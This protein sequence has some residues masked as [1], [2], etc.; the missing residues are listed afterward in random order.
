MAEGR[1][2]R[3][4]DL[5]LGVPLALGAFALAV[6]AT[7]SNRDLF[8]AA[9]AWSRTTG[10]ALW[11]NVT[12]LGDARLVVVLALPWAVRRPRVLW[13]LLVAAVA[14]ALAV[15][16]IKQVVDAQRPAHVVRD[17]NLIGPLRGKRS[18]PSGHA[19]S[20][21]LLAGLACTLGRNGV[22]RTA[23]LLLAGA[24]AA[25]RVVIGVHWPLD[26]LCGGI[27]GWAAALAGAHVASRA[28]WASWDLERLGTRLLAGLIAVLGMWMLVDPAG[29]PRVQ[30]LQRLAAA[31]SLVAGAAA[32]VRYEARTD[33]GGSGAPGV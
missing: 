5:R 22:A 26:V 28:P 7:G 9:N 30:P 27:V 16:V 25:S 23:A 12:S 19:A 14:S 17:M 21:F 11:A 13:A 1:P 18:F 10:E 20:G 33:G 29:F 15:A 8:H 32:W 2:A 31:L 3:T 6:L 4:L 24:I